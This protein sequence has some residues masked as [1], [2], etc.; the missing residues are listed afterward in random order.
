MN[1]ENTA[2]TIEANWTDEEQIMARMIRSGG[3]QVSAALVD[4]KRVFTITSSAPAATVRMAATVTI[5]GVE[6]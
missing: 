6:G 4:G 3:G 2:P 5:K 1:R